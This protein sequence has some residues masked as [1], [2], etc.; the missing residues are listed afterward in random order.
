MGVH[1]SPH[2]PDVNIV[3]A[4]NPVPAEGVVA[5]RGLTFPTSYHQAPGQ[6]ELRP[7]LQEKLGPQGPSL[8]KLGDG[9]GWGRGKG[10]A[11]SRPVVLAPFPA[12]RSGLPPARRG[13]HPTHAGDPSN[14]LRGRRPLFGDPKKEVGQS[15]GSTRT[16]QGAAGPRGRT[17]KEFHQP[18]PRRPQ[19]EGPNHTQVLEKRGQSR[20]PGDASHQKAS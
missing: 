9:E 8:G 14:L 10:G 12:L 20:Q 4:I 6:N 13:P 11:T 17:A 3:T 5:V 2:P 16:P 15:P 18:P 7:S 1:P 19:R